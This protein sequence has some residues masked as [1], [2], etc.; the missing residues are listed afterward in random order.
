MRR[1]KTNEKL[2][3]FNLIFSLYIVVVR[4]VYIF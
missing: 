4:L 2:I 1:E 3:T